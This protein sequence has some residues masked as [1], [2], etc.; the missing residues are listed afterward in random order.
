MRHERPFRILALE[1]DAER[2]ENL[3]RLVR[4]RVDAD[5]VVA[6]SSSSAIAA[7]DGRVPDLILTSALALPADDERL[8]SHVKQLGDARDL[9][10]LTVPPVVQID[11]PKLE[12]TAFSFL[13]SRRTPSIPPY[14]PEAVGMRIAQ[15]V[16]RA[17]AR[18]RSR[19]ETPPWERDAAIHEE[20]GGV[21]GSQLPREE[22]HS[23][24][25]VRPASRRRNRAQRWTAADVPW[26]SGVQTVSGIRLD[27]LNISASGLLAESPSRFMP[28]SLSE[29][30]LL[31]CGRNII[32]PARLVRSEVSE[33]NTL[34]VKYQT[35]VVFSHRL[36][37]TLEKHYGIP[38]SEF[39]TPK[40]LMDL[41]TRALDVSEGGEAA[42]ARALFEQGLRELVPA[43]EIQIRS[44]P[45][46]AEGGETVYFTVPTDDG[47]QPILQVT[48]EPD[49][50]PGEDELSLLRAAASVAATMLKSEKHPTL[51][52]NNAW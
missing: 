33:V 21:A 52:V 40:V 15:A 43:R 18:T 8:L 39:A 26:F 23:V 36:D 28:D 29:L 16:A 25:L 35:A 32:V 12:R 1:P 2:G 9:P 50:Q 45:G 20:T 51:I 49:Y 37:L 6:G 38:R 44:R 5:V 13:K 47:S 10:I 48:F 4:A 24:T 41:L 27:L 30:H 46:R 34:G 42:K 14:D 11:E 19:V 22:V 17:R 3:K 7:L 31:G